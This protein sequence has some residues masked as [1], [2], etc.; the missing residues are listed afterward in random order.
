LSR[1]SRRR[2]SGASISLTAYQDAAYA[3]RYTE[4]LARVRE[5]ERRVPAS[6]AG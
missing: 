3:R 2:S 1:A 5:A 6:L 4:M